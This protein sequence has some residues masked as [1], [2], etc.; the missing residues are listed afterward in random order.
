MEFDISKDITEHR[1]PKKLSKSINKS[2]IIKFDYTPESK[3]K[4]KL[5]SENVSEL[6][7]NLPSKDLFINANIALQES[8]NSKKKK[9]SDNFMQQSLNN[10]L[11]KELEEKIKSKK[12]SLDF[13]ND[14]QHKN[15]NNPPLLLFAK[16]NKNADHVEER[17]KNV[18]YKKKILDSRNYP[19]ANYSKFKSNETFKNVTEDVPRMKYS[20]NSLNMISS[21]SNQQ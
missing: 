2:H 4:S 14:N 11:K 1:T 10:K 6:I 13:S 21:M 15:L 7:I 16:N 17:Y 8:K 5:L 9:N 3:T 12:I 18:K 19:L 20:R